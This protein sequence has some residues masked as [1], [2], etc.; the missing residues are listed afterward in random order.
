MKIIKENS[1]AR[2][3]IVSTVIII[4][5]LMLF[6]SYFFISSQQTNLNIKI[7]DNKNTFIANKKAMLKR[8]VDVIIELI[9]FKRF[10]KKHSEEELKKDIFEWIR[11]VRYDEKEHNYVFVYEL[12]DDKNSEKFIKMLINPNRPDLE[13]KYVSNDYTDENGKAFR[14]I[15]LQG[16]TCRLPKTTHNLS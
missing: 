11:H 3:I 10:Q 7:E 6:S 2:I 13:G 15:F 12:G 1:I 14:K 9:E 8:E 16:A 5:I 4:T